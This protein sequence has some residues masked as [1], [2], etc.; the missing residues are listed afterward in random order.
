MAIR[1]LTLLTRCF[2]LVSP[3][4]SVRGA[5][6]PISIPS[7]AAQQCYT[8]SVG[9]VLWEGYEVLSADE[10]E[11]FLQGPVRDRA[12]D[13]DVQNNLESELQ[14]LA[15]TSVATSFLTQFLTAVPEETSWGIGE[16]LAETILAHDTARNVVWPWN[17]ARDRRTP[18]ASLPGADLV[19]FCVDS[20]GTRLLFGEVKTSADT[21]A[22]PQV[23]YGKSGMT[24]QLE[25]T[26]TRLD[27]QRALLQ[28]L[29]YRCTTPE[30]KALFMQAA[31]RYFA[32]A[33]KDILI[34]GVLLRDTLSDEKDL[35]NRAVHLSSTL[36]APACAEL[37][38][39]YAPLPI[40][41]W[42]EIM[43]RAS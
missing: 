27:I 39:W 29:R 34:V 19:G 3:S 23:M 15:T 6:V 17:E 12:T 10:F 42:V 40:A 5:Q 16:A 2:R 13:A 7:L 25:A 31:S 32:S 33:G 22:P 38:A 8:G 20:S 14:A 43:E 41:D 24:W 28:W 11:A 26:A 37:M 30:L 9:P 35:K 4:C 18:Q 1:F 21:G 36:L